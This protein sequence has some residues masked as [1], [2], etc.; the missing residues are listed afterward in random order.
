MPQV[1]FEPTIAVFER[2]KRVHALDRVATVIGTFLPLPFNK[3]RCC[4]YILNKH[5]N[6]YD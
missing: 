5:I 2:T 4:N 3:C 1:E 6:K